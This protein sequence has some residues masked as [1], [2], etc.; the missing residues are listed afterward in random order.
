MTTDAVTGATSYTGRFIGE[1][2]VAAGRSVIDLTRRPVDPH[3]LGAAATS[4]PLD[5]ERPEQL[6][7]TLDGVDTLYNTFWIRFER[8][9]ITYAWAVERSR[10]L[11]GAASRAGVRHIVHISVINAAGDAP[12]P[13]FRA[14]AA[15]EQ[16]LAESGISHAIVRPTV[17]FGPDDI[18]LNNLAWT[19]RRLPVFGIPGDGRYPIQP[20]HI[21]D[22]ADLAVLAGSLPSGTIVDAAGPDTFTFREFVALVRQAIGSHAAIVPMPVGAALLAARLI[23]LIVRDVVLTRDEVTE[24][25]SRLMWSAAPPTGTIRLADWLAANADTL[26]RSWASELDRHFRQ[27]PE[28]PNA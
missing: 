28:A 23:G 24:L 1:R 8:G 20:V 18:L 7:R 5:F 21:D 16:A 27:R 2:L 14:K 9:P 26:G 10:L 22:I 3:P 19:L 12:T 13:Y 11:F 25:R 4:A 17:T 6:A 15:V